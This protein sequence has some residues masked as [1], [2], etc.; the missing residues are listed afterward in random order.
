MVKKNGDSVIG[1]GN[2]NLDNIRHLGTHLLIDIDV[3]DSEKLND[4][5]YVESMMRKAAIDAGASIIDV[6]TRKFEPQGVTVVIA[7]SESH[8]SIHTWPEHSYASVDIFFCGDRVSLEIAVKVI[9][10][11]LGTVS[12]RLAKVLRG[13]VQT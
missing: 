5:K 2:V 11:G 8:L 7:V 10:D 6:S 9:L 4:L 12:Y 1:I 13:P 3:A